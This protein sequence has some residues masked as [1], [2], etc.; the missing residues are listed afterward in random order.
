MAI[1]FIRGVL[2]HPLK[3]GAIAPSS[4][5]LAREMLKHWPKEQGQLVV[6]FGTGTGAITKKINERL[7]GQQFLGFELN[8]DFIQLLQKKY[9]HLDICSR[10]AADLLEELHKRQLEHANLIVSGLP[11]SIFSDEL[12]DSILSATANGL[13]PN[14]VF[15]TFAYVHAL[16][17][18]QAKAFT[19]KL[20]KHFEKV[21]TSKVI[22]RNL[23]PAIIYHCSGKRGK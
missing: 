2:R 9:P 15:S 4:P 12:Q 14:G 23:P 7:K 10:S 11:W 16:K 22:W 5:Y 17:L 6:E 13:A 21:Q 3:T 8:Q 1:N 19:L 18:K 20:D